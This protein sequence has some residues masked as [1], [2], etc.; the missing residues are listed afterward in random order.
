[1][2][3]ADASPTQRY[4]EALATTAALV[5]T[6]TLLNPSMT[7]WSNT[8]L[9]LG[10]IAGMIVAA[11]SGLFRMLVQ[12]RVVRWMLAAA[13]AL[14][15]AALVS[16]DRGYS[17][18]AFR[19]EWLELVLVAIGFGPVFRTHARQAQLLL[20]LGIAAAM[21]V[22]IEIMQYANE[23]LV[24]GGF[25]SDIARHRWYADSLI[26][27]M[28]AVLALAWLT[29]GRTR[30]AWNGL[31]GLQLLLLAAT[32]SR[33]AWLGA[34][35]GVALA[36]PLLG[37]RRRIVLA[38]AGAG[39]AAVVIAA[40]V[41]PSSLTDGALE[42]GLSTTLRDQ[43]T[44]GPSYEMIAERPLLGFGYGKERFH[45]EFNRRAPE[46]PWWL[47]RES[48]GPHSTYLQ[49]LFS[50]GLVG[51]VPFV[52]WIAAVFGELWRRGHARSTDPRARALCYAAAGALAA[53][54]LGRGF[55]EVV[56]WA[57]LGVIAAVGVGIALQRLK[58]PRP[59]TGT[60]D[61][62]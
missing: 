2:E 36:V 28:P 49:I 40:Q 59:G 26:F 51:F 43:G 11:G 31:L 33:G 1:M 14:F 47:I 42:R 4:A 61:N 21:M 39:I 50:A 53:C 32:S 30:W 35:L 12:L 37:I 38:L 56:R 8:S 44:W 5:Y 46:R 48:V 24:E 41:L 15:I 3:R 23:Y 13:A 22:A 27:F 9:Y 20:T 34:V 55:V 52:V 25:S 60:A 10:S 62:A 17:L 16:P 18:N 54:Y 19:K 29:P 6:V 45:T 57:P 58:P 7:A